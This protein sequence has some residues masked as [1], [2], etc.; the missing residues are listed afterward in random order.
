MRLQKYLLGAAFILASMLPATV[1]AKGVIKPKMYM[2]G[3]AASF[4]DT[5]VHFTDV[6]AVD[7]VWVNDK[8]GFL[9]G[10]E[11]YSNMLREYLNNNQMPNR[12]C[13]VIYDTSSS[14]LQKKYL[15][16]KKLY[17]G[18]K[19]VKNRNDIRMIPVS[20]FRFSSVDMSSSVEEETAAPP[21][22]KKKK[23]K[24]EPNENP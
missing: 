3:F 10:R 22:E 14:K 12:T 2:F 17:V 16:M 21:K 6:Q 8:N 1:S 9:L 11:H 7:S 13:I 15:K 23:R 24:K 18:N 4:N 5:I 19:K 20:D